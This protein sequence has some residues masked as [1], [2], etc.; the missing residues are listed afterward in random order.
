MPWPAPILGFSRPSAVRLGRRSEVKESGFG[1]Q[2]AG[3]S[4]RVRY[5]GSGLVL[6]SHIEGER[7]IVRRLQP[8]CHISGNLRAYS[9][10]EMQK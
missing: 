9:M 8:C 1:W 7:I 2:L 4:R 5:R 3:Y 6:G 10:N